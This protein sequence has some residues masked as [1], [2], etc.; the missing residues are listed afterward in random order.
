MQKLI[1]SFAATACFAALCGAAAPAHAA[2]ATFVSGDGSDGNTC[3]TPTTAC[4]QLS[5]ASGAI[6][7]TDAF[8]IVHVLPG[9]YTGFTVDKTLDIRAE[10]GLASV[11]SVVLIPGGGNTGILVDGNVVV[12]ISGLE[13]HTG[14]GGIALVGSGGIL[15]IE[16]CVLV[17]D[18]GASDFGI[19]FRPSGASE[20]YVS[21]TVVAASGIGALGGGMQIKPT[22]SGGAK[23]VLDNTRVANNAVG[24]SIDG[25]ATTGSNAVTVR[26]GTIAGS[27]TFGLNAIDSGGGAT[28][29]MIEGSSSNNNGSQGVVA[30]GVN[31][32]VR[33]R[34]STVTGN[35]RGLIFVASGKIISHGGNVVAGNTVNGA[36]SSSLPQQ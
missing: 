36:F 14:N 29:V 15:H 5:G 24:I 18:A 35:A 16:N 34:D 28:N 30:N 25:R 3:L 17:P 33:M 26:N 9:D 8:G 31:T 19:D 2:F 12:R 23:V 20:L 7:K 11:Q 4:R 32:T 27:T 1:M 21:D 13:V 10:G 22:G 6:S